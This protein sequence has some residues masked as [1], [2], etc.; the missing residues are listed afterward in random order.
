[1]PNTRRPLKDLINRDIALQDGF[2]YAE[3]VKYMQKKKRPSVNSL[4]V[5]YNRNPRTIKGWM[6]RYE[7]ELMKR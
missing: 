7:E 6:E 5:T 1:M 2:G 4:A 3:F